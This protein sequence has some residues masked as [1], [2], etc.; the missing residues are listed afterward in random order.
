[1]CAEARKSNGKDVCPEQVC[2]FVLR[3]LILV[4]VLVRVRG[5]VLF[6]ALVLHEEET[7]VRFHPL[8]TN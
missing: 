2:F 8:F 4:R 5:L 1:M 7:Q 3:F 6:R